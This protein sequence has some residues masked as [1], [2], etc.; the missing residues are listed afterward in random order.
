[1]AFGVEHYCMQ[2][3]WC[4]FLATGEELQEMFDKMDGYIC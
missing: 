2:M 1:M 3:M 4:S